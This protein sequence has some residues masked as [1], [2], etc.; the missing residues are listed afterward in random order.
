MNKKVLDVV[1]SVL[2]A[3]NSDQVSTIGET[4]ESEQ[5]A[6]AAQEVYEWMAIDMRPR[7]FERL[8]QLGALSDL[9]HPVLMQLEDGVTDITRLRYYSEQSDGSMQ[10]KDVTYEPLDVFLD[11]QFK[12]NT[13]RDY[14]DTMTLDNGTI[15]PF[16][17]DRD[18]TRYTVFDDNVVMF[19]A[20]DKS[21]DSTLQNN[22]TSVVTFSVPSWQMT[23]N[24][25]IP[26]PDDL[27]PTYLQEL[28]T[29]VF[30]EQKEIG[31]SIHQH[32]GGV[33]RRRFNVLGSVTDG[34]NATDLPYR[35]HRRGYGRKNGTR[36]HKS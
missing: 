16:Y 13:A 17:N 7:S 1:Q 18:P 26:F 10:Y 35:S 12:I 8:G 11:N 20:I 28:K 2:S 32:R 36:P 33:G 15:V 22:K 6:L 19:D 34:L 24:W 30:P 3:M 31:A 14:V 29:T 25:E 5:V 23:D 9:A 21:L 4:L 27:F